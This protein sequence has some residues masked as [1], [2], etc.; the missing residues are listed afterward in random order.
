MRVII[1]KQMIADEICGR[2]CGIAEANQDREID[3]N[4]M[5][6]FIKNWNGDIPLKIKW[7]TVLEGYHA[8]DGYKATRIP[9]FISK[10]WGRAFNIYKRLKGL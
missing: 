1:T 6:V 3:L 8:F 7:S 9:E 10:D 2:L 4:H 5:G